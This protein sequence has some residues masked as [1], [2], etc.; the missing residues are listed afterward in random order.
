MV[1]LKWITVLL[2]PSGAGGTALGRIRALV[3]ESVTP[4]TGGPT[5]LPPRP[6]AHLGSG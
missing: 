6:P 1:W 4:R 3:V 5:G 2:T